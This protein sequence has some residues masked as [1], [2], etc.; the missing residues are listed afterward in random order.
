MLL[1][2]AE[3]V[4]MNKVE[5]ILCPTDLSTDPDE[6]LKHAVT[7]AQAYDA[8]LLLLHCSEQYPLGDDEN[9]LKVNTQ[10]MRLF[11]VSLAPYLSDAAKELKWEGLVRNGVYHV[12]KAIVTE[13]SKQNVD[14]IVL[15]ARRRTRVSSLPDATAQTVCR[16]APC[17]V[18]VAHS[19][20]AQLY[21]EP[22]N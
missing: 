1:A 17:P 16:N 15:R 7:L 21:M 13:A 10:L 12:G 22:C 8:K 20:E 14:L 4:G 11:K 3:V 19:S 5:R 6:A 2:P 18:I 9:S